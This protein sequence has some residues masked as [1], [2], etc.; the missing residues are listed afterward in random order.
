MPKDFSRVTRIAELIHRELAVIIQRE[1]SD[2]RLGMVTLSSVDVTKDLS[3][4]KVHFTQLESTPESIQ[5][6]TKMLNDAAGYL[7]TLVA[8]R[9][10]IRTT[11][12]LIFVYDDSLERGNR[13]QKLI[14]DTI[15]QE[16]QNKK[17]S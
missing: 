11:P 3:I 10:K 9:I 8:A 14:R 5:L 2:P 17:E 16:D 7:R 12:K 13:L 6:G 4:A 15:S 1:M